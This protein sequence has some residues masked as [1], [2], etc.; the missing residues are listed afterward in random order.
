[1]T[2]ILDFDSFLNDYVKN[3][4]F[5]RAMSNGIRIMRGELTILKLPINKSDT[6]I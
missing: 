5:K 6:L 1:M 2:I 4:E 3:L